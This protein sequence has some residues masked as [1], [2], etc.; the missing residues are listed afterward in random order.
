MI[1]IHPYTKI[2]TLIATITLG[3][4]SLII[5]DLYISKGYPADNKNIIAAD[6]NSSISNKSIYSNQEIRTLESV[7]R[8]TLAPSFIIPGIFDS[9]ESRNEIPIN[10]T[11]PDV[12]KSRPL[13]FRHLLVQSC[14]RRDNCG[15]DVTLGLD[16]LKNVETVGIKGIINQ[17]QILGKDFKSIEKTGSSVSLNEGIFNSEGEYQS[18]ESDNLENL[19]EINQDTKEEL[20][21]LSRFKK[22]GKTDGIHDGVKDLVNG[23]DL[24]NN[25]KSLVNNDAGIIGVSTAL[26]DTGNKG[27][28]PT[29]VPWQI[30][31]KLPGWVTVNDGLEIK[32]KYDIYAN[33]ELYN[34]ELNKWKGYLKYIGVTGFE[35]FDNLEGWYL[36]KIAPNEGLDKKEIYEI[37]RE[38][39][40]T[41]TP[42][43][44]TQSSLNFLFKNESVMEGI[45]PDDELF[46]E[47]WYLK[48]IDAQKAWVETVGSKDVRI[49]L[50]DT[51]VD[52]SIEDLIN[53]IDTYGINIIGE[54]NEPI[55]DNGHGT[56]LASLIG[57][58][59]NNGIGITGVNWQTSIMPIKV[60]GKNKELKQ[61]GE[62]IGTSVDFIKGLKEAIDQGVDIIN[63]SFGLDLKDAINDESIKIIQEL[64]N[65]GSE[66][67]IIFIA[68]A[69]N[70]G[71]DPTNTHVPA[72]L[73]NVICVTS[74]DSNGNPWVD[75]GP[76]SNNNNKNFSLDSTDKIGANTGNIVAISAP[77]KDIIGY[78]IGGDIKNLSGTSLSTALV[79]GVCGLIKSNNPDIER[80]KLILRLLSTATPLKAEGI[81]C[82]LVNAGKALNGDFN[83]DT[84]PPRFVVYKTE[85][86]EV[87]CLKE[88]NRADLGEIIR[89]RVIL[90]NLG[91]TTDKPLYGI[92]TTEHPAVDIIINKS[93]VTLNGKHTLIPILRNCNTRFEIAIN[94]LQGLVSGEND[95]PLNLKLITTYNEK[96]MDIP[97]NLKVNVP[98]DLI[99][100]DNTPIQEAIDN[101]KEGGTIWVKPGKYVERL[102]IDKSIALIG[103]GFPTIYYPMEEDE[104]LIDVKNGEFIISGFNIKG[105]GKGTGIR[106]SGGEGF[107]NISYTI[108][109]NLGKA[110]EIENISATFH[111]LF[112]V[113]T[114]V[115]NGIY[116]NNIKLKDEYD[117]KKN[118]L[119]ANNLIVGKKGVA[120]IGLNLNHSS[121]YVFYN[122]IDNFN[123]GVFGIGDPVKQDLAEVRHNIISNVGYGAYSDE[124]SNSN[125]FVGRNNIFVNQDGEPLHNVHT[126][127]YFPNTFIDPKY[128]NPANFDYYGIS[129]FNTDSSELWFYAGCFACYGVFGYTFYPALVWQLWDIWDI[130][131]GS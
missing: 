124:L 22:D 46:P 106:I 115:I 17:A 25:N 1:N 31:V 89:L 2:I 51:G 9:L 53:N 47:Q 71:I 80:E 63:M 94:K 58:E 79:S 40:N 122:T 44:F 12:N 118:T 45:E 120:D 104:V 30:L 5:S 59:G 66:E 101:S 29:F 15:T 41:T 127:P 83:I 123:I 74:V 96:V 130:V 39:M 24:V 33:D 82:G 4:R 111:I 34:D 93:K 38:I 76:K 75:G 28:L 126:H 85:S 107:N 105:N 10:P 55:D 91:P 99:V 19:P 23:E 26:G 86:S 117:V 48:S 11:D 103:E 84:I 14:Q 73:E 35:K 67:G 128:P 62:S 97:L 42:G 72:T 20:L 60:L 52:Y 109:E 57:A 54:N 129:T 64:I 13:K 98:D 87:L 36:M 7:K 116:T 121:L 102:S 77:G 21:I 65:K 49:A 125:L 16:K 50:L 92:L 69:G 3:L 110:I 70:G 114:N 95:I 43:F 6:N 119:I 112:N 131:Q 78:D 81:G 68:S 56:F 113:I 8:H 18:D 37:H 32:I 90:R 108:I 88:N 100:V 27:K 61:V